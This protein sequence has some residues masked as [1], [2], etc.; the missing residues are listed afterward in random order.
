MR[1]LAAHAQVWLPAACGVVFVSG[2]TG[3]CR[4]VLLCY[5]RERLL[6]AGR[7]QQ[8]SL[9]VIC[10]M[11]SQHILRCALLQLQIIYKPLPAIC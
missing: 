7:E 8:S 1:I 10:K 2:G 5:K 3:A 4:G 11:L 9:R 6:A